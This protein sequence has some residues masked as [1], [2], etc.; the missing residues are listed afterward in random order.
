MADRYQT[1]EVVGR[2]GEATVLKAIDKRHQRLVALKVRAIPPTG[3]TDEFLTE[4]RT[5]LSLPSH[6]RPGAR[7]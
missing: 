5:L 7:P 2:G 3:M 6:P 1:I 4:A